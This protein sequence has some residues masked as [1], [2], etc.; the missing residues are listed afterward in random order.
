MTRTPTHGER[1]QLGVAAH[2]AAHTVMA[3]LAGARLSRVEFVRGVA[4]V[5]RQLRREGS[6]THDDVL[7]ALGIA[8]EAEASSRLAAIRN[9]YVPVPLTERREAAVPV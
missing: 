4:A 3:V 8:S 7:A 5:G 1:H 6:T 2:E 9:G